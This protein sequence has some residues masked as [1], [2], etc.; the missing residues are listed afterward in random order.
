[1]TWPLVARLDSHL[2]QGDHDLW[3]N[4]WNF[5]SWKVALCEE[6]R[7]PYQT[8]LIYRPLDEVRL[9]NHTHSPAN[10]LWT[11]P[12]NMAF[13]MAVALN[14]AILGGFVL[15]GIGAYLLAR[16]YGAARGSA[17]LAGI[18][19][20]YFPQHIEQGLE[21]LNLASFY[22]MPFFLWAL[23]RTIRRGG[24]WW[25]A[26]GVF[27]ALNALLS[28]HN[29]LLIFVAACAVFVFEWLRRTRETPT[30]PGGKIILEVAL[31]AALA[32]LLMAPFLWPLVRDTIDGIAVLKKPSVNKPIDPLFLLI[33]HS[34]HPL[35]GEPLNWLY[36]HFRSYLSVGF[37]AYIGV[38]A[39]ALATTGF[40]PGTLLRGQYEGV[41]SPAR[42]RGM[43]LGL[44]IFYLVLSFG[45]TLTVARQP[46]MPMPFHWLKEIPLFGIVR[47]PNRF[48]VPA[49]LA[50]AIL[51]AQGATR[52]MLFFPEATRRRILVA[53]AMLLILDYAW[54]PFPLR[55]IPDHS[56]VTVLEAYPKDI[57]ILNV[58]G[59]H[60]A[61]ASDDLRLQ[62]L[63]G[64]PMVSGYSS[65]KIRAVDE[66]RERYPVLQQIFL[67]YQSDTHTPN[68]E[69]LDLPGTARELGV[70]LVLV[71]L[72]RTVE[73]RLERRD[74]IRKESGGNPYEMR[75]HN[76]EKGI[77]R[78]L[79]DRF[80]RELREAFGAPAHAVEG[81]VEIYEVK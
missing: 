7:S 21:H 69:E 25:L 80:R 30:R 55:S 6:Q 23:A 24:L 76:P 22:A 37:V 15:A 64:R 50:L 9:G 53:L 81:L 62:T 70:G 11:L 18:V 78:A 75:L 40:L 56:W 73:A 10:I 49:M 29:A 74:Q 68:A 61:R 39:L 20:A 48:L 28:W 14:L 12:F 42:G 19:F 66:L 60:N 41:Q 1:M 57:V 2:P 33:P 47:V 77:P 16:E 51:T 59:G 45:E 32:L 67:R 46:I 71:H 27:F 13:G 52:L 36:S 5:W 35:W 34:G 44:L 54:I 17:F 31:A 8:T 79:L 3:Q 38:V 63:H 4:Y 26:C 65:S 43:W 58:P 72:D